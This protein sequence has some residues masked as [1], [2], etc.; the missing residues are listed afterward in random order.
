MKLGGWQMIAL[1]VIWLI[2]VG[3]FA[4]MIVPTASEYE[5]ARYFATKLLIESEATRRVKMPDNTVINVPKGITQADL[6]DLYIDYFTHQRA[7]AGKE[8]DFAFLIGFTKPAAELTEGQMQRMQEKYRRWVDFS[9]IE[10]KYQDD[11]KQ[12]VE[13]REKIWLYALLFWLGSVSVVYVFSR[14]WF[15]RALLGTFKAKRQ[16]ETTMQQET[17]YA[18]GGSPVLLAF[19]GDNG[20]WIAWCPF[21]VKFHQHRPGE[22]ERP[23]HCEDFVDPR[24]GELLPNQSAFRQRG[25]VLRYAGKATKEMRKLARN[26]VRKV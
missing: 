25:Y 22:G 16:Q 10:A 8:I 20:K 3:I 15:P 9:K 13:K 2:L 14:E 5:S 4:Q 19:E 1:S 7:T 11:L 18:Y 21:C 26:E 6:D 12:L 17:P 23:A 24:T